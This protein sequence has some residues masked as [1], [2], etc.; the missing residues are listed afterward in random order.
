MRELERH[1]LARRTAGG[2]IDQKRGEAMPDGFGR[3]A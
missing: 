3:F 1:K 2:S